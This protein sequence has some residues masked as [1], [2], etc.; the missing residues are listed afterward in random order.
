MPHWLTLNSSEASRRQV[1]VSVH[2]LV[3]HSS[4]AP[5]KSICAPTLLLLGLKPIDDEPSQL[6]DNLSKFNEM[7]NVK[8][9]HVKNMAALKLKPEKT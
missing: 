9:C 6:K 7:H 5:Y 8:I 1:C 2:A 3:I 4:T